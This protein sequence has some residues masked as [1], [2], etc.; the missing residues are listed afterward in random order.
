M[1]DGFFAAGMIDSALFYKKKGIE[2]DPGLEYLQSG[3]GLILTLKGDYNNASYYF[4][5]YD[6]LVK[7]KEELEVIGVGNKAFKKYL[8]G[9]FGAAE[10]L[11]DGSLNI[12]SNYPSILGYQE[13][14]WLKGLLLFEKGDYRGMNQIIEIF[15]KTIKKYNFSN[16]NYNPVFKF[17]LHLKMLNAIAI[18]NSKEMQQCIDILNYQ[19]KEKVKDHGSVFDHAFLSFHLYKVFSSPKYQNKKEADKARKN[20]ISANR[21][22]KV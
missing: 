2:L 16:E 18:Q 6:S 11:I 21:F 13:N 9:D 7:G 4:E 1:G 10:K 8:E 20:A 19:I 17:Y 14:Y 12:I 5:K 22:Y 15:T 3:A